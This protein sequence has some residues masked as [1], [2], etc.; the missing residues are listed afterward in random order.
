MNP[1]NSSEELDSSKTFYPSFWK[2]ELKCTFSLKFAFLFL[3][4][5]N[6]TINKLKKIQFIHILRKIPLKRDS[7]MFLHACTSSNART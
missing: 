6:K 7:R 1:L 4:S 3:F 5:L 2:L